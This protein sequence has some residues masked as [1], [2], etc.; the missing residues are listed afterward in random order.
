[1]LTGESVPQLKESLTT[2]DDINDRDNVLMNIGT[3]NAVSPVWRRHILFSGTQ[4]LQHSI[5]ETPADLVSIPRAR[6]GGVVIMA[7]KTGYA[8]SQGGLMRKIHFATEKVTGNTIETFYFIAILVVF[9]M[10]ASA[11]V[12]KGGME[13]K[14]R[15]RFKL[16]LHCIMI[17]TS[18]IP[19]ELPME[20]SLAVTNSLAAL[21]KLSVYCTEPFRIPY[22]GML[23]VLCFDKTGTLTVDKMVISHLLHILNLLLH[24]LPSQV[25]TGIVSENMYKGDAPSGWNN[26]EDD[27]DIDAK[28]IRL[29][30]WCNYHVLSILGSCHSL[31]ASSNTKNKMELV[32]DPLELAAF[33][34]SGFTA[35][36]PNEYF[37]NGSFEDDEK[38]PIKNPFKIIIKK[39]FPFTSTL[40]RMSVITECWSC[41]SNRNNKGSSITY[42][43]T[44]GAP[45]VH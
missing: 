6:D 41:D 2:C 5:S 23:K 16:V 42:V 3:D 22:G 27:S 38:A 32:G 24:S 30:S 20:L 11:T 1:M 29:T 33:Q 28:D 40:K 44:K 8:T 17:I 14:E 18:V 45:E 25:L 19:P 39:R 10:V 9:A 15:N 21:S 4:L 37:H 12:L 43:F 34:S 7:L 26:V 31:M 35:F 36:G 13:D